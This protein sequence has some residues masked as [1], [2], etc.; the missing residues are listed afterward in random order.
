M[1]RGVD[2]LTVQISH[3]KHRRISFILIVPFR[4]LVMLLLSHGKIDTDFVLK[5]SISYLGR[6]SA[7][8]C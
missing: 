2:G 7:G 3:L 1:A 8:H 4:L 6:K 5:P